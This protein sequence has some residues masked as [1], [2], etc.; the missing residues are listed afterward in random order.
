MDGLANRE[1]HTDA[2]VPVN[3]SWWTL[4]LLWAVR[5]SGTPTVFTPL[6]ASL[7]NTKTKQHLRS[8]QH[9]RWPLRIGVLALAL[10]IACVLLPKCKYYNHT[11]RRTPAPHHRELLVRTTASIRYRNHD[12][13]ITAV[14]QGTILASLILLPSRPA[15]ASI[16]EPPLPDNA[17]QRSLCEIWPMLCCPVRLIS[18]DEGSVCFLLLLVCNAGLHQANISQNRRLPCL[19]S[20]AA[21]E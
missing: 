11:Q 3:P 4:L 19:E 14:A 5:C 12:S 18:S 20:S 1:M 10:R 2:L 16:H 13:E 21:G 7:V 9:T 17:G 8:L 15:R 6:T